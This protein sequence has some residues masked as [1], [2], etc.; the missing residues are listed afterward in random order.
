MI[1]SDEQQALFQFFAGRFHQDFNMEFK[2]DI[3]IINDYMKTEPVDKQ[4]IMGRLLLRYISS[5][6]N[7]EKLAKDLFS[8]KSCYFDP[9]ANGR[10][11][12]QWLYHIAITL[13]PDA[14]FTKE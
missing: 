4:R 9:R 2:D 6:P 8:D 12:S 14:I 3:E 11:V 1:T 13:N 10:S 5:I 7:E